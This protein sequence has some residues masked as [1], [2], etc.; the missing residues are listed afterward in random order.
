[1]KAIYVLYPQFF[2]LCASTLHPRSPFFEII[3]MHFATHNGDNFRFS[4]TKLPENAIERGS[5]FPGHFHYSV[6]YLVV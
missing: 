4:D 6:N 5:V 1:M 2:M 3:G